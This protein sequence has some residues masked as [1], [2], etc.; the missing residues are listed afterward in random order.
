VLF[1]FF[2]HLENQFAKMLPDG[3][4]MGQAEPYVSFCLVV[5]RIRCDSLAFGGT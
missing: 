2:Y 3:L 5:D 4:C 1:R